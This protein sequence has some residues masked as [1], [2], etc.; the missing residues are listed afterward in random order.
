[1]VNELINPKSIVIIGGSKDVQKPGGRILKNIID[2]AY[3]GNL[4][5]VNPK[6]DEVQGLKCYKVVEELPQVDLAILAIPA[7]PGAQ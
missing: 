6:E 3:Q 4:Y 5:V 7:F 1:M 2:G